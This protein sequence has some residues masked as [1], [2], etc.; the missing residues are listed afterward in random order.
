MNKSS[1]VLGVILICML[2]GAD[3]LKISSHILGVK[4]SHGHKKGHMKAIVSHKLGE[5]IHFKAVE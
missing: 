1:V 5:M 2:L 4:K 3:A